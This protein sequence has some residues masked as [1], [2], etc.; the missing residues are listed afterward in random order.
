[1][2]TVLS[3]QSSRSQRG[4]GKRGFTLI[5]LLVVI[6]IIALLIALLLPAL[7][8]AKQ[9]SLSIGCLAN[10]RSL[11]QLTVEYSDSWQDAIPYGA[12][13]NQAWPQEWG[14]TS[15]DA[16]LFA[17]E[18]GIQPTPNWDLSQLNATKNDIAMCAA[19]DAMFDCPAQL[20]VPPLAQVGSTWPQGNPSVRWF[21][22]WPQL[23]RR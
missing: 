22:N 6:S 4:N 12:S 19:Y 21:L 7:A 1:M 23:L 15:W 5:E 16:L 8:K 13:D 11:G 10:L 17:F 20:I 14:K 9:E 18:E 2:N 3:I